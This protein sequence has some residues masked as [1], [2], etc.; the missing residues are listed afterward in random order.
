MSQAHLHLIFNHL[1]VILAFVAVILLAFSQRPERTQLMKAGLW[2]AVAAATTFLPAY[3]TGE[4]TEEIVEHMP[5]VKHDLIHQH[6]EVAEKVIFVF[7][8]MGTL[9]L[10]SLYRLRKGFKE[11]I[12]WA[13]I[14][15]AVLVVC[16]AMASG[17]AFLGSQISHPEMREGF[18]GESHED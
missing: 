5:H 12:L 8:A 3:F 14:T 6:E 4:G 16:L 18:V 11:G 7:M 17:T 1:P 10:V 9:A 2:I 13:R 15:L